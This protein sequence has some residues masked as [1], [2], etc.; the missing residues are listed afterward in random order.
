M[1]GDSLVVDAVVHAYNWSPE[2]Y[3]NELAAGF[4]QG[5][6][7]FH[8]LLSPPN[9]YKLDADEFLIDWSAEQ[10]ERVLFLESDVDVGVYH[11]TPLDDYF[12]DGLVALQKGAALKE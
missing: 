1:I 6:Y 7:G 10:I 4:A 8:A 9:D 12:N 2:N 11:G 3:A 5:G